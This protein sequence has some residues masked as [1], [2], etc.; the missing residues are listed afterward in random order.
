MPAH[1]TRTQRVS[2]ARSSGR[3][4]WVTRIT[5]AVFSTSSRSAGSTRSDSSGARSAANASAGSLPSTTAMKRSWK[6]DFC[7]LS[8]PT[9]SSIVSAIRHSR[10]AL[11]TT[12]ASRSGSTGIVNANVRETPGRICAWYAISAESTPTD[13]PSTTLTACAA[14]AISMLRWPAMIARASTSGFAERGDA[15]R[16]RVDERL[17]DILSADGGTPARLSDAMRYAVLGSGKRVRPLL[18]YASAELCGAEAGV[19]SIAA[20]VELVHA[21]SL[22]HDA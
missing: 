19:D 10:Y 18:V 5:A 1:I 12:S 17:K 8:R 11:V 13:R 4:L 20:A 16:R 3:K 2:A 7:T 9:S 21:Y 22:V 15:Y 6:S 14:C